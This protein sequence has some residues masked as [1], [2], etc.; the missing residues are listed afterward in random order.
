LAVDRASGHIKTPARALDSLSNV[1]TEL[2]ENSVFRNKVLAGLKCDYENSRYNDTAERCKS[3][4]KLV[5][6][7]LPLLWFSPNTLVGVYASPIIVSAVKKAAG[8]PAGQSFNCSALGNR[9]IS[10]AYPYSEA[11]Q[12]AA[13][14]GGQGFSFCDA[15]M[16]T[17]TSHLMM[18][19]GFYYTGCSLPRVWKQMTVPGVKGVVAPLLGA[20]GSSTYLYIAFLS[21]KKYDAFLDMRDCPNV[22]MRKIPLVYQYRG[23]NHAAVVVLGL[24]LYKASSDA[25]L[26][27]LTLID[28]ERHVRSRGAAEMKTVSTSV[29]SSL[30][31][32]ATLEEVDD[33][34]VIEEA[35]GP[36]TSG[37]QQ[38]VDVGSRAIPPVADAESLSD[39]EQAAVHRIATAELGEIINE[40]EDYNASNDENTFMLLKPGSF[41]VD[42]KETATA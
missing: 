21:G 32:L 19:A 42:G 17:I 39:D 18:A 9:T 6:V 26:K 29:G 2:I 34:G 38:I 8:I 27:I 24:I 25:W 35:A 31:R 14:Y 20:I 1:L 33:D 40:C 37:L 7:R 5:C 4:L 36:S 3:W 41:P 15:I 23:S 16:N 11:L 22:I 13:S 12:D 30:V 28:R 10:D